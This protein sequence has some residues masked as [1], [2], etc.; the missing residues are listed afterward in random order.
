MLEE[1]KYHNSP[2]Y[3]PPEVEYPMRA[4]LHETF[5]VGYSDFNNLP[6]DTMYSMVKWAKAQY[7]TRTENNPNA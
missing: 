6:I 4:I 2:A 3:L 5:G 1:F 7:D